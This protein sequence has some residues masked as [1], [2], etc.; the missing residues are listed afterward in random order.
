MLAVK[1]TASPDN[2]RLLEEFTVVMVATRLLP[3]TVCPPARVPELPAKLLL[4][5]KVDVM[6]CVPA[7][8]LAVLKVA[9]VTPP[10]VLSVPWPMLVDP[11]KK[12]TVPVGLAA[13]VLP[14]GVTVTVAV[15]VTNCPDDGLAEE[16][17]AVL[18][19]A[20]L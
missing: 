6:E 10:E 5:P 12:D 20:G 9:V 18:V 7:A 1:V 19:L 3:L 4:P 17:T 13:A 8:K 11:S 16:L 15:K 2:A 14:G